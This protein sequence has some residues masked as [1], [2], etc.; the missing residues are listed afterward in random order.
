MR[1]QRVLHE[2]LL[3]L[4]RSFHP[5]SADVYLFPPLNS[6]LHNCFQATTTHLQFC[7]F[8]SIFQKNTLAKFLLLNAISCTTGDPLNQWGLSKTTPLQVPLIDNG[9]T[10]CNFYNQFILKQ[11]KSR[12]G[13][14]ESKEPTEKLTC[15]I[16]IDSVD[17]LEWDSMQ[18]ATRF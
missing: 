14:F 9:P 10:N 6:L 5:I 8:L 18:Q 13:S 2:L 17:L 11:V 15:Q 7:P 16:A 4:G 12:G 1:V 3:K